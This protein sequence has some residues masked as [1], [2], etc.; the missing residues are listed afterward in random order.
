MSRS[1]APSPVRCLLEDREG[2]LWVGTDGMGVFRLRKGRF[3]QFTTRQ[4]LGSAFV[5]TLW[6]DAAGMLWVGTNGY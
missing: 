5:Q 4:G 3:E 1:S 6:V 2:N